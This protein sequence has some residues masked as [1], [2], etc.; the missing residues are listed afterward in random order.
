MQDFLKKLKSMLKVDFKRMFTM[1]LVYVTAVVCLVIPIL[2]LVMTAMTGGPADGETAAEGFTNAWQAIGSVSGSGSAMSM[3]ITAMCNINLTYFLVA[4]FVCVFVSEDFRCGYAKNLFSV[5]AKRIDYCISKTIA[6]T[7]GGIILLIAY[8]VGAML[9]GAI[10]GLPFDTAGFG[11]GGIAACMFSKVF[12]VVIFVSL[13]VLLSVAGKQKLWIS[14]VGSIGA[15]ALLFTMLPMISPL[16]S[17]IVNAIMCLAGGALFGVGSGAA[18][19]V[20]LNKTNLA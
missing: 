17:T 4:I 6:G 2:I 19:C 9:G 11:A 12:L 20:I 18:S 13:A 14:I 10:A 5:R 3:D 7:V 16:D 1:P 8:F 15:S